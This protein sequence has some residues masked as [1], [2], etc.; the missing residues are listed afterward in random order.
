MTLSV[1]LG[2]VGVGTTEVAGAVVLGCGDIVTQNTVLTADVG[3][4][5]LG[6]DIQADNIT[7]DLN[8]H[9]IFGTPNR[10]DGAGVNLFRRT[11][12]TVRNGTI[13][14]FD[15]GVI[16]EGGSA[17][18]LTALTLRDNHGGGGNR[19]GDGVAI[20]SSTNN[21]VINN[22]IRN[23]GPFSGVG[24][25]SLID[26]DHPRQTSGVSSG[27]L[28]QNN[29]IADN[30]IPRPGGAPSSTDN[31]GIRV[32]NNS[33][34]NSFIAN[35]VTGSGLDG[36]A[37]FRGSANNVV[38]NNTVQR[39][40]FFRTAVRRGNGIIMFNE[41]NNTVVEG[42]IV[43]GNADNGIVVQGPLGAIAGSTNN[44]I[45]GNQSV[46]NSVL[47]PL[48]TPSPA[49]SGPTFDLQDRNPNCDNNF[50]FGNRYR[51]ANPPCT[52]IGGQ[53]V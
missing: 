17:N 22:T 16:I 44:R 37:L 49:F 42:N 25:Y 23:N 32:E 2:L 14:N 31:D 13:S 21:Q 7:L 52:T 51:T 30:N 18:T 38:R 10:G 6:I 50:W 48:S 43:T 27:N 45:V 33:T 8:G 4:C 29:E 19:A 15:A 20:E 9:R 41:A 1:L 24:L 26:S 39:N 3:P 53:Q 35:R 34:G 36:I 11:G 5:Q 12:V 40:G 28:I 46:G 47:P